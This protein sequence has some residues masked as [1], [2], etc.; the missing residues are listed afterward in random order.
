[1]S[2]TRLLVLGVVRAYGRA[3][4]YLV[5]NELVSWGAEEWANIKWGSLYHALRQLDKDG[6]LDHVDIPEWPGRVDY[7]L[8]DKGEQAFHEMLREALRTP[9][10]RPDLLVAGV[11]LLPALTREEAISLLL[12]R[13]E[14]LEQ[15][16]EEKARFTA[17]AGGGEAPEHFRELTGLWVHAADRGVEWTRDLVERLRAG[18]YVMAGEPG[19]VFGGA[20]V[21][22]NP[23]PA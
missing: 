16:R 19:H 7:F 23:T 13:I 20:K 8:T 22:E 11:A 21:W 1:M 3:H 15:E 4:G 9:E 5:R 12:L 14:A 2:A 10:H 6:L 17:R 18:A